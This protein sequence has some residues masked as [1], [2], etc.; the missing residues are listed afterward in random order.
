MQDNNRVFKGYI[1][2]FTAYF[3]WG[4]MPA[5]FKQLEHVPAIEIFLHRVLW[6]MP[7]LVIVLVIGGYFAD[8]KAA[9]QN[10]KNLL[11]L[12]AS[13]TLLGTNWLGFI[14][15]VNSEQ[16]LEASLG[17]YINPL[18][19]VLLGYLFLQERFR[20]LQKLAV[21]MAF[22]GVSLLVV[23]VS[24]T[25]PWISLF[26]AASFS[27]YG[28]LRKQISV[29]AIPGLLIETLLI[30]P[31]V[32]LALWHYDG[33]VTTVESIDMSLLIW[34]MGLGIVSTVPLMLFTTAAKIIRYSTMG[35]IQYIGPTLMFLMA[36]LVYDEP[37]TDERLYTFMIVWAALLVFTYDAWRHSRQST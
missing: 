10:R 19:N 18:F 8:L 34:L 20:P 22:L 23:L 24:N 32:L 27:I 37:F 30:Y 12:V 21:A 26:L 14:W 17:Y 36:V 13:G 4:V 35:F 5:Y 31:F 2:A 7:F 29:P 16:M 3:I 11:I 25:I 6:S 15:A 28:A 33:L 9:L 1:F